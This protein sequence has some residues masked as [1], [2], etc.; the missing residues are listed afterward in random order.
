MSK[1]QVIAK[2]REELPEYLMEIGLG[3]FAVEIGV[4]KGKFSQILLK[5]VPSFKRLYMVDAWRKIPSSYNDIANVGPYGHLQAMMQAYLHIYDFAQRAVMIR[6][7]SLEASELFPDGSLDFVYLDA[8]HSYE[9]VKADLAAWAKKVRKGGV[10]AGHDFVNG[11][12]K[13]GWP[14]D[15]GVKAAVEEFFGEKSKIKVT[16]EP[17]VLYPS[18]LVQL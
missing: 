6:E 7:T 12:M 8:D 15:F 16:G 17:D 18:W 9:G 1:Y 4:Q 13:D 10:I 11:L 2:T 5:G 14:A 3:G